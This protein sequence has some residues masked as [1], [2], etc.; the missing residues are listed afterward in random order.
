MDK[1]FT[2]NIFL[3]KI[4]TVQRIKKKLYLASKVFDTKNRKMDNVN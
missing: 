1:E 3:Q 2:W 4:A